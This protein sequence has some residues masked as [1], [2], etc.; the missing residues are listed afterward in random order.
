[1][2]TVLDSTGKLL[3]PQIFMTSDFS[4]AGEQAKDLQKTAELSLPARGCPRSRQRAGGR[5]R[6]PPCAFPAGPG[7][8]GRGG[9]RSPPPP[10]R[11]PRLARS[12]GAATAG[13]PPPGEVGKYLNTLPEPGN[14]APVSQPNCTDRFGT[15]Y[16]CGVKMAG[17]GS[18]APSIAR[19]TFCVAASPHLG[20]RALTWPLPRG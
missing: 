2:K 7:T 20:A 5:D 18:C 6:P 16:K 13:L 15:S 19:G 14:Y 1:M 3:P 17:L 11:P 4:Q 10:G 12:P 9:G 8:M